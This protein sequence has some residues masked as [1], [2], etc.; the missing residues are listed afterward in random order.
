MCIHWWWCFTCGKCMRTDAFPNDEITECIES[1]HKLID[2]GWCATG[3]STKF[4]IIKLK[5]FLL[6]NNLWE[7]FC[8]NFCEK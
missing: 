2:G 3:E 4:P 6:K 8:E 1:K 7:M 5:E